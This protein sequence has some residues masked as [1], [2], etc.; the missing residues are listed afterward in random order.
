MSDLHFKVERKNRR[1]K[2]ASV[3]YLL[4][5][6]PSENVAVRTSD[7]RHKVYEGITFL[8]QMVP[9][10]EAGNLEEEIARQEDEV[11][12]AEKKMKNLEE[13][14]QDLER[15]IKN[16]EEKLEENRND[17]RKQVEEVNKQK[18][19]LEAMKGRRRV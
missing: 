9:T 16:L 19:A 12:K 13:D 3:V 8:N 1:D 10:M 18:I 6:R 15:K 17:Q 11:K 14:Q 4:V 2:D 7:D 5:G